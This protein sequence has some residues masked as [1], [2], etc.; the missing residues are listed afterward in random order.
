M[1]VQNKKTTTVDIETNSWSIPVLDI[2][3]IYLIY[4]CWSRCGFSWSMIAHISIQTNKTFDVRVIRLV[5]KTA[6][7]VSVHVY[8]KTTGEFRKAKV[9]CFNLHRCV[10]TAN[11]MLLIILRYKLF[12]DDSRIAAR[13]FVILKKLKFSYRTC[14]RNV[15]ET[16]LFLACVIRTGGGCGREVDMM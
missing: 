7:G 9:T 12:L 11:A 6:N 16:S 10:H 14:M 1:L 8:K 4:A 5:I 15:G 3:F 2:T 13:A